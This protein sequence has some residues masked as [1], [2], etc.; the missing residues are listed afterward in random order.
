MP[1]PENK[2][3]LTRGRGQEGEEGAEAP[4]VETGRSEQGPEMTVR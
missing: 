1:G 3:L 4:V 2:P